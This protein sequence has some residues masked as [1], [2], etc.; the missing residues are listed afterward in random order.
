MDRFTKQ[1]QTQRHG[2]HSGM[3]E[4]MTRS[5]GSLKWGSLTRLY[6]GEID[7]FSVMANKSWPYTCLRVFI[8][9]K[10]YN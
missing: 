7:V 6:Y 9:N 1:K 3:Q 2:C 8:L 4:G 5:G 10:S